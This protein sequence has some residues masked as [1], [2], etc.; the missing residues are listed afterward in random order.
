VTHDQLPLAGEWLSR[1]DPLGEGK[2]DYLQLKAFVLDSLRQESGARACYEEMIRM[3]HGDRQLW[4]E[5]LV[6]SL[7]RDEMW[8]EALV[9]IQ[10][11]IQ[12]RPRELRFHL[13]RIQAFEALGRHEDLL[14]AIREAEGIFSDRVEFSMAIGVYYYNQRDYQS[15]I[16]YFQKVVTT[17]SANP[18][19]WY[20]LA[21]CRFNRYDFL[22]AQEAFDRVQQLVPGFLLTRSYYRII[23]LHLGREE[24]YARHFGVRLLEFDVSDL[25][26]ETVSEKDLDHILKGMEVEFVLRLQQQVEKRSGGTGSKGAVL[27]A[28]S[29]AHADSLAGA[30]DSSVTGIL[31]DMTPDSVD[32]PTAEKPDSLGTNI[33]R[34]DDEN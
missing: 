17:D 2:G 32:T 13:S 7:I 8:D 6:V 29:V 16:A 20:R 3:G 9:L 14:S 22:G 26:A 12:E 15:A 5:R 21:Q 31:Q 28:D 19:A 30:T 18:L 10:N 4:S 23:A 25:G 27:G 11:Q 33:E 34:L 1:L 24:D